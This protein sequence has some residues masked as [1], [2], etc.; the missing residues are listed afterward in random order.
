MARINTY[1]SSATVDL[2]DVF[3]IDG[4]KGTRTVGIDVVMNKIPSQ[5]IDDVK[6]D[7]IFGE[8]TSGFGDID[9]SKMF[10]SHDE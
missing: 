6:L 7:R 5:Y 10:T 4:P 8:Q 9:F 2:E 1:P 3:L